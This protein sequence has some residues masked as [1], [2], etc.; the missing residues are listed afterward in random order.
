LSISE[1]GWGALGTL[2]GALAQADVLGIFGREGLDLATLW[3]PPALSDPGAFAF[4]MFRNYDGKDG[5]FGGTSVKASSADQE[6][7]SIYA[8][9]RGDKALTVIVIN[10]SGAALSSRLS[11]ASFT[12]ASTAQVYRYDGTDLN[13]THHLA[14]QPVGPAGFT[15]TFPAN[16]ITLF[17]I[18]SGQSWSNHV[19]LPT[20]K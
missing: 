6:I 19:F 17:V 7:L 9:L 2:N 1:Y 8:A 16:S 10:K 4:R 5:Q 12:P 13:A 18:P 15:A 20:I 11:L 14:D 3:G